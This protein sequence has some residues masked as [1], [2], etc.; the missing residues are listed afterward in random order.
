MPDKIL[1][2]EDEIALQETLAY[3]LKK[4][5]YTVETVG[6]GRSALT[7]A[8]KLKPDLIVL[9]IMLPEMDGFEVART[10]RKEMTTAILMLTARDDE[11]DRVVGLEVGADDY[12][13]KP[14]SMRELI[15]RVKAQLRRARLLREEMGRPAEETP[16][17]A[18]TFDN[19]TINL[20]RREVTLNETPI[21]LKPKEYELL[22]FLAEH[23]RQMLSR[24]FI[25]ERVWGWDYIGDSRTVD[26]HVRWLRQK[27]E[28]NSSEPKR[29]VT[30]RGGGYRFEG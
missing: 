5:G 26:V 23:R 6:D 27:I 1:I 20:T 16:H 19:L 11:I 10:L 21:Q 18:L 28:E 15:A 25:L 2:V 13:T 22:L 24:E 8:R 30:V 17:E 9:D 29:I 3:N 14:F 7:V 4:E 12:M